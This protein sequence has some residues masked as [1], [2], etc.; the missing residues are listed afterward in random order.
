LGLRRSRAH[1]LSGSP[2]RHPYCRR[3]TPMDA[4]AKNKFTRHSSCRRMATSQ[5]GFPESWYSWRHQL[6]LGTAPFFVLTASPHL[7]PLAC[8]SALDRLLVQP[9]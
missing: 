7:L 3:R 9:R 5:I 8:H 6:E 2:R 1:A 4:A